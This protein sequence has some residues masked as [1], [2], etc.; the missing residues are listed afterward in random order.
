M[1]RNA[2][3]ALRFADCDP[4]G[5][6]AARPVRGARPARKRWEVYRARDTRLHRDVALKV[7]PAELSSDPV[8]LTRFQR[9]ARS[10]SAFTDQVTGAVQT[11][12][13]LAPAQPE[14]CGQA[15]TSA[16]RN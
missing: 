12:R 16:F 6:H 2:I 3:G 13:R 9:E 1:H 11:Y 10:A 5:A 7:L 15:D 4:P 14:L 8:R